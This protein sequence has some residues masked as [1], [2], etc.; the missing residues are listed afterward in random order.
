MKQFQMSTKCISGVI[1]GLVPHILTNPRSCRC[2]NAWETRIWC[3]WTC[4]RPVEPAFS[5]P[6]SICPIFTFFP[7][8]LAHVEISARFF[9]EFLD[10]IIFHLQLRGFVKIT[11]LD[12]S[13][14]QNVSAVDYQPKPTNREQHWSETDKKYLTWQIHVWLLQHEMNFEVPT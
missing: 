7:R 1:G 8:F 6:G 14:K 2:K 5:I 10:V 12:C 13:R 3:P 11:F 4:W 9:S